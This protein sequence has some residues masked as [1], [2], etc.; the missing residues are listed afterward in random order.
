MS[1]NY[2]SVGIDLGSSKFVIAVVK[3]GGVEILT[4]DAS[5]RQTP[6]VVSYGPERAIG[7]IAVA[8]IKKNLNN[9]VLMPPRFIGEF[10][11]EHL[12]FEKNF[13]FSKVQLT[14]SKQ[15]QFSLNYEGEPLQLCTE[16]L[17]AALFKEALIVM[18]INGVEEKEAVV[19]VPS[20]YTQLDRQ[21]IIDSARV[22]GLEIQK[23]YNESAANLMNYG[24]FRMGDLDPAVPRTVAF[25]DMG[26]SKTTVILASVWKGKGEILHELSDPNLGTRNMD[27]A[28][29]EHYLQ[30]FNQ[31]HKIDLRENPKSIYRLLESIEKQRKMLTANPEA[32]CSVESIYEEIDFSHLIQR[33][34]F[35]E[36]TSSVVDRL[37][38]LLNQFVKEIN[39]E[40]FKG[41][42]S[43]ERIG[44]G[45][46]IP[47]I[48]K[49]ITTCF[50]VEHISKTV[51]ANESVARGCAI[52]SAMLSP[53]FKVVNYHI[54][55]KL[56]NPVLVR[57]QYSGEEEKTKELFKCGNEFNK[58]FSIV[59]Q[60]SADLHMTLLTKARLTGEEKQLFS[61]V[62]P[63]IQTKEEKFEA[64]VYFMLDRNGMAQIEKCELRETYVV[65]EKIP[66]KKAE[67]PKETPNEQSKEKEGMHIE[68]PEAEEFKIEKKEKTRVSAL[69]FECKEHFKYCC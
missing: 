29:L 39:P 46:R 62:L 61:A 51:D 56:A 31:K 54:P 67:K 8:K 2:T 58:N 44:G 7:D 43:V 1:F 16:Q 25:V 19:S 64:K 66:I 12:S 57:L 6:T 21:A 14:N 36:I 55:E 53:H 23:L 35:E 41:L 52:Q 59:V 40:I 15:P 10:S 17:L 37:T 30:V 42:H 26:H 27:L 11:Q 69:Q 22:A 49:C 32:P 38:A 28:I 34:E 24:I 63:R 33:K 4:N 3:K 68:T 9:S 45:T 13:N 20:Y 18:K 65:E 47:V 5:Y 60:K 50:K 48:E